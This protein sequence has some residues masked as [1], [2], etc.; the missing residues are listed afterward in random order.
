MG[1]HNGLDGVSNH[2]PYHA[3]L[4]S[5]FRRKSKKTSASL[6]FVRGIHRWPVNSPHKWPVTRKMFPFDDVI[7]GR[8][9]A[10]TVMTIYLPKISRK[11]IHC[12]NGETLYRKQKQMHRLL[13]CYGCFMICQFDTDDQHIPILWG[14]MLWC[15]K[16]FWSR[17]GSFTILKYTHF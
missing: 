7:M 3:L 1:R 5:L 8:K 9:S 12:N 2:Q 14:N 4:K 16:C 6:A 17:R 13:K 11:H 15:E 10:G